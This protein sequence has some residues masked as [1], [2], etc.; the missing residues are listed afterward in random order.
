[1]EISRALIESSRHALSVALPRQPMFV[2]GDP[3]RLAQVVS[4]LL[5]NAAKYTPEQGW[6]WLTVTRDGPQAV[7][8]VKDNG[9]GIPADVLPRI[10]ELFVQ[11]DRSL[12]RAR[13]GLGLG[14]SLVR[15]LVELHGGTV[16]ASS[17]GAGRGSE[18]VVRLPLLAEPAAGLPSHVDVPASGPAVSPP[19][20]TRVL[21]VDDN[22]DAATML[23]DLLN[24]F[25]L[26]VRIAGDGP[27]A[28]ALARELPPQVVLLDIG[29][30]GMDGY[31]VARRL[32]QEHPGRELLL[33][34]LTGYG[35]AASREKSRQASFDHHLVK[36]VDVG[37][38]LKLVAAPA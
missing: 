31:D 8:R 19:G 9:I 2:H 13:G 4:N 6:I 21:I 29:L 16:D 3:V 33:I 14:L 15:T 5:N 36:P 35:D 37:A 12:D 34:A 1:V 22:Q 32:R 30:P 24:S 26:E 11:A 10:F 18:L 25:G 23:A 38:I 7:I 27:A 28:L 17:A 20:Q